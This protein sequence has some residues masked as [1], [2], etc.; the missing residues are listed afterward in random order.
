MRETEQ[1][2]HLLAKQFEV[3]E[4][5]LQASQSAEQRAELLR[6]MNALIVIEELDLIRANHSS[7]DSELSIAPASGPYRSPAPH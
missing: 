4:H 3:L 1:T 5:D 7:L 2:F 6:R